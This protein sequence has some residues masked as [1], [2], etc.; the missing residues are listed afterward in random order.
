MRIRML[1]SI[2]GLLGIVVGLLERI[3]SRRLAVEKISE[4]RHG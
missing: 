3:S 4:W 1:D 2:I